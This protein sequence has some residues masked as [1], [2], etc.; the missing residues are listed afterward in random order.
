MKDQILGF[1]KDEGLLSEDQ[2]KEFNVDSELDDIDLDDIDFEDDAPKSD[3]VLHPSMG[4]SEVSGGGFKPLNVQ[5]WETPAVDEG[6]K[7]NA[8]AINDMAFEQVD[9]D[10]FDDEDAEILNNI[11]TKK[12]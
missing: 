10:D 12:D 8:N 9:D 7:T 3:D 2:E 1:M 4:N 5:S 11:L 6:E